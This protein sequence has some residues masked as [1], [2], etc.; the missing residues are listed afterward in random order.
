MLFSK[1]TIVVKR[2]KE[3]LE[4]KSNFVVTNDIIKMEIL[5]NCIKVSD[6][7]KISESERKNIIKYINNYF[8]NKNDRVYY[9]EKI[10]DITK[11][12][13][14]KIENRKY[15]KCPPYFS[16][17]SDKKLTNNDSVI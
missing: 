7:N 10:K 6:Q 12:Y 13:I 17:V 1:N 9:F 8:S 2:I 5:R 3:I 16:F 4:D 15:L 14:Q 11:E